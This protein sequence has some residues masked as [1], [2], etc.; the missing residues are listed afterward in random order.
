MLRRDL[1]W[2]IDVARAIAFGIRII[3]G[4]CR[5]QTVNRQD[6][7]VPRKAGIG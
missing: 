2:L 5:G 3:R 7:K 6:A 1:G 4:S